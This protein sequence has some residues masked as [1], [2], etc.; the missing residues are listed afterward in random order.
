MMMMMMISLL[1]SC[2]TKWLTLNRPVLLV[3]LEVADAVDA[4]VVDVD[5]VLAE[6][7]EALA[8]DVMVTRRPTFGP[9]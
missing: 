7:A 2:R 4:A 1:V 8:A 5:V 6:D 9:L 3:D